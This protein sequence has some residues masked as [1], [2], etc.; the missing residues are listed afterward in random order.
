MQENIDII[1]LQR[2][3]K[4]KSTKLTA[5]QSQYQGLDEVSSEIMNDL[6]T[7]IG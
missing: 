6:G 5:L 2:E 1:R 7:F 3:V 4:E